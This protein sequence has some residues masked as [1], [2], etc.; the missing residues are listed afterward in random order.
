MSLLIVR[1]RRDN[2]VFHANQ[3]WGESWIR[4]GPMV[5]AVTPLGI[6]LLGIVVVQASESQA[7]I[8]QHAMVGDIEHI[9][10]HACLL[11]EGSGLERCRRCCARADQRVSAQ[12]SGVRDA[13]RNSC[14]EVA[15]R[16]DSS[17]VCSRWK[18]GETCKRVGGSTGEVSDRFVFV[19]TVSR[20][21]ESYRWFPAL[22]G[23]G[24]E[25]IWRSLSQKLASQE[26]RI[27]RSAVVMSDGSAPTT[28]TSRKRI[29]RTDLRTNVRMHPRRRGRDG[30]WVLR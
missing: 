8:E 5:D 17:S 28:K 15:P 18:K 14:G 25:G 11:T 7:A 22:T 3:S 29:G 21:A 20:A 2:W 4:S 6:D 27:F 10:R 23:S 19:L 1:R 24:A 30:G 13:I 12:A 26:E 9:R 16:F